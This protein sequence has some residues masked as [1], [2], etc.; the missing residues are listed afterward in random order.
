MEGP[1]PIN[2]I[3]LGR[4][5]QETIIN[6]RNEVFI[7][8]PGGNLLYAAYGY[9]LWGE[10]TGLISRVGR[11]YP[12]E[13]VTSIKDLGFDTAGITRKTDEID[14]RRFYA[15]QGGQVAIDNPQKFF[16]DLSLPFPKDL[17]GYSSEQTRLNIRNGSSFFTIKPDDVP[18]DYLNT[19]FLLLCPLDYITHSLIP[20]FFRAKS[21]GE[22]ILYPSRSYLNS[23]FYYDF[24][25]IARGAAAVI[26]S[27]QNLLNLFLGRLDDIWEIAEAIADF[28]VQFVVVLRQDQGCL[29]YDSR[30]RKRL[31]LPSYC[32]EPVD[33]IGA[34]SAFCGGF[35]AGYVKY[36]DPVRAALM[37]SITA[38]I[39]IQGSTAAY[40]LNAMPE[41]A[42]ARLEALQDQV[43]VC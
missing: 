22:V 17:L 8:Q 4:L 10:R 43:K 40:L 6:S 29:L 16:N 2:S 12:Q 25:P 3:I 28:G 35:F 1:F 14:A 41:L 15:V 13:W 9:L 20:A 33:P 23:S 27:E 34:E 19:G 39:K 11:N 26:A 21:G 18:P 7:N 24:P 30:S 38:S 37:G 32:C 31:S 36:L 42:S 5:S